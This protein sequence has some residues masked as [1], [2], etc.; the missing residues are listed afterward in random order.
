MRPVMTTSTYASYFEYPNGILF[1]RH[2]IKS[3]H[4]ETKLLNIDFVG[5]IQIILN[6]KEIFSYDKFKLDRIEEG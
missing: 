6:G 1:A 3:E 2:I 5:K 4:E